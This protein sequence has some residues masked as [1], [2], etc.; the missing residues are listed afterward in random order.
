MQKK[1]YPLSFDHDRAAYL[2]L[3]FFFKAIAVASA[4]TISAANN[5]AAVV[6]EV[7][8]AL[9]SGTTTEVYV[10]CDGSEAVGAEVSDVSADGSALG[11]SELSDGSVLGSSELSDGSVLGSSELS[12]GSVLG[13]SELS[14][15]SADAV[16]FS[17]N[18]RSS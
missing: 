14:D 1:P 12:D 5:A 7:F 18:P 8:G 13:S 15:G 6:S 9:P 2:P 16:R 10:C 4:E 11:S 17:V 3:S